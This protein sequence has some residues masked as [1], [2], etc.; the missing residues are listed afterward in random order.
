M[1]TP[2]TIQ[3]TIFCLNQCQVPEAN[4]VDAIG[5][6]KTYAA[7]YNKGNIPKAI[8][9]KNRIYTVNSTSVEL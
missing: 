7:Q 5:S 9:L 4:Y 6:V 1:L 2:S 8:K 3:I